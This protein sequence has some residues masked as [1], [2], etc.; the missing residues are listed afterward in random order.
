MR[1]WG[2]ESFRRAKPDF[3]AAIRFGLFSEAAM[4][5]LKSWREIQSTSITKDTPTEVIGAKVRAVE[6]IPALE[7]MLY[8]EDVP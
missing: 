4:P 1:G 2:P 5:L 8:P 6:V 3:M 7:A